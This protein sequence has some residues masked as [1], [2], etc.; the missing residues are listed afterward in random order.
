MTAELPDRPNLVEVRDLQFWFN[1][2][3]VLK[4]LT[5]DVPRGKVVGILGVSGVGK[6]TLLRL[7]GGQLRPAGGQ[8]DIAGHVVHKLSTD[9]LYQLRRRMGMMFQQSGLFTDMT[10]FDNIAFPYRE[11]TNLP[12]A[13]IRDLVLL[14]LQA[15]GLRGAHKLWPHELSGGMARRIALARAVAMDPMLVMYDEPFAGLDPI[16]LNVIASLI[17]RLNEALGT[18]AIVVTYDAAEALK[19]SDYVYLMSEGRVVGHG[20]PKVLLESTDPYV[21]QFVHAEADGPVAFRYPAK[22]YQTE[23]GL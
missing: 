9:Q 15:V 11:H 20:T 13:M 21:H 6:T 16:S 1:G 12:E 5:L 18:T 19:V 3:H 4:G 23:L 17:R 2:R 7:I 10:V 14:K 8:V 22:P